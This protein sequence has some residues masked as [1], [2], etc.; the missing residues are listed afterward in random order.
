MYISSWIWLGVFVT[1][2]V[3][4]I[5][6]KVTWLLKLADIETRQILLGSIAIFTKRFQLHAV[7][8]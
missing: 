7:R 1:I 2:S 8:K 3:S 5:G 6:E 4:R